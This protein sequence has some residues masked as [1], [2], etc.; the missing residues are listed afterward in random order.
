MQL[1]FAQIVIERRILVEAL[2]IIEL[3]GLV[4]V[5]W[6]LMSIK[7]YSEEKGRN[8]ATKEDI[9]EITTKVE[10]VKQDYKIEFE[11]IQKNNELIFGEIKDSKYRYNAE[12]FERYNKL[13]VVLVNLKLS[14][15]TL[16]EHVDASNL[17]DF[18]KKL[19]TAKIT[20]ERSSLLIEDNH[21]TSL[22]DIITAFAEYQIG[23]KKLSSF[24]NTTTE[25]DDAAKQNVENMISDNRKHM[26][27]Y[28]K[29]IKTLRLQFKN[30]MR[31]DDI[32]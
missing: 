2:S 15:D 28:I 23:K 1:L 18:A 5:G 17:K 31:G 19:R 25:V 7:K 13:W 32:S 30:T 26:R 11:K 21:Y 9:E 16:W 22:S 3:L 10:G 24:Y 12:Q 14:A 29:L 8:L 20:I 6:V 4:C 27:D